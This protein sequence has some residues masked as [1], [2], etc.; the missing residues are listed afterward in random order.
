MIFILF[1]VIYLKI[2]V[3]KVSFLVYLH[4]F[5]LSKICKIDFDHTHAN[6][7]E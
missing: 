6:G 1:T 2:M 4:T 3:E 7:A 5:V